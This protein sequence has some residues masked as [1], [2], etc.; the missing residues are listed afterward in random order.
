MVVYPWSI[1]FIY[2]TIL[3][4]V[5]I[6]LSLYILNYILCF[7]LILCIL[8]NYYCLLQIDLVSNH[9]CILSCRRHLDV[10]VEFAIHKIQLI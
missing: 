2:Y 1:S 8:V 5:I 4:S 7:K 3:I 9:F 10:Q 6:M